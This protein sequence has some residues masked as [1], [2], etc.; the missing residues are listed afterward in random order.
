MKTTLYYVHDPM[1]SW[2]WGQRP[3]W[4]ELRKAL[5][6]SVAIEYVAGGLAPDSSEPM[7]MVLQQTIQGYWREIQ[8]KLGTG[9]NF[10]FWQK[11]TPRRST[12][13]ACRAVIAAKNQGCEAE[14]IDAIQRAYYLRALNPS[15]KAV[16]VQLARE[17]SDQGRDLDWKRFSDDLASAATQRELRRQI[18]LAR[19]LTH[20]GFPSMVLQHRGRRHAIVREYHDYRPVLA[21]IKQLIAA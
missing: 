11:N 16:L 4:D 19:E 7:P 14:M 1:C 18:A 15:D 9:F 8:Q 13:I 5:P 6:D 12:Y 10:D 20:D 2:C 3:L 21:Q 17:L